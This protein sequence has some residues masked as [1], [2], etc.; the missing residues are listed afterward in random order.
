MCQKAEKVKWVSHYIEHMWNDLLGC[1]QLSFSYYGCKVFVFFCLCRIIFILHLAFLCFCVLQKLQL[2]QIGLCL[3]LSLSVSFFVFVFVFFC[4]CLC[5]FPSLP[6]HL[7]IPV[8]LCV[9]K[10]AVVTRLSRQVSRL[11]NFSMIDWIKSGGQFRYIIYNQIGDK[12][13]NILN[14]MYMTCSSPVKLDITFMK[15]F[16]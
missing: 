14:T 7:C 12:V 3:F 16:R 15:W 4:L 1:C 9:G 6:N 8:F 10:V 2:F 5:P 11:P 13:F